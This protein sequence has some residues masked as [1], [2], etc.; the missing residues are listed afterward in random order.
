MANQLL[1]DENKATLLYHMFAQLIHLFCIIGAILAD[2]YIGKFKTILWSTVVAIFGLVTIT[3]GSIQMWIHEYHSESTTTGYYLTLG[4]TI[5]GLIL[6]AIG[7][8][9]VKPC[10][11]A[12]GGEQ[13]K[14]KSVAN[15]F[16]LFYF[17][18]NVGT[19]LATFVTPMLRKA[20]CYDHECY[21]FGFSLSAFVM[22][23]SLVVFVGGKRFY[24]IVPCEEN[25]FLKVFQCIGVT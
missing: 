9:G 16:S 10:M 3:I 22:I 17:V 13:A 18:V 4:L 14:Q 21:F 6:V 15:F 12:F 8:G 2:S 7:S 19:V 20:D 11:L 24:K 23:V 1:F 5:A 25:L